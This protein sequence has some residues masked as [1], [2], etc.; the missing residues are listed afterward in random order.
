MHWIDDNTR[1]FKRRPYY[2]C[3]ELDQIMERKVVAFLTEHYKRVHYPLSTEDLTILLEQYVDDLD[4]YHDFP[5]DQAYCEGETL[6]VPGK[7]PLVRISR[8]LSEGGRRENRQRTTLAHETG[9]VLLHKSL[10]DRLVISSNQFTRKSELLC[11]SASDPAYSPSCDWMEYQ[12]GYA[13]SAILIPA[14][15]AHLTNR[16]F[17]EK[18]GLHGALP[19]GSTPAE[20]L[21]SLVAEHYQTSVECA[22]VR[23]VN[24]G[25]LI[26]QLSPIDAWA[27]VQNPP[28][29]GLVHCSQVVPALVAPFGIVVR[30][31][32]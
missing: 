21:T 9:H 26:R 18:H 32:I 29:P 1:R 4:L 3:D 8:H 19:L 17:Q 30:K 6:F 2:S 20:D 25:I 15:A 16:A 11:A 13:C 22:R 12:A 24:M 10:Y 31:G 14:S 27:I 5:R 7:R 28:R 23:L